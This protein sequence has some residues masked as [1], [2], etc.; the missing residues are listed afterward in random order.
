MAQENSF[1]NLTGSGVII[2]GAGVLS[3]MYVNSTSTGILKFY[4]NLTGTGTVLG[5]QMTPA[6]GFHNL[7]NVKFSTG[8]YMQLVSGTIDVTLHIKNS[9]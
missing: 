7:G 5:G 6:I 8:C 1:V 2:A 3:S 4:N 9:D